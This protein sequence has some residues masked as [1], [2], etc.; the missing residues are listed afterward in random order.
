MALAPLIAEAKHR[1][2]RRRS[3]VALL[4]TFAG[5]AVGL[6]FIFGSSGPGPGV[7]R[8]L[9][10][11]LRAGDLRVSVPRGLHSYEIF[12]G[13]LIGTRPPVVGHVLTDFR[14]SAHVG[15]RRV[16]ARWAAIQG[17]GPPANEVALSLA[18]G[19]T[20]G[21]DRLHLPLTLNQPW[22]E[23]KLGNGAVGYRWGFFRFH[24]SDYEVMYWSGLAAPASDRDAILRALKSIRPAR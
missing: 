11:S 15:I 4:I 9:T 23:E 22:S 13:R 14:L 19:E 21:P 16:F 18:P 2:R 12:G 8:P 6:T 24:D 7:P 5:L 3:V 20:L 10:S 1:M 17:S